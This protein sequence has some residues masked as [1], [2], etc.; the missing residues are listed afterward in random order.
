LKS[1]NAGIWQGDAKY[2]LL[3]NSDVIVVENWLDRLLA[4]ANTDHNIASVNPLTNHAANISIP[5]APGANYISMDRY[6]SQVSERRYPDIVT[7]VGFC[8]LLRRSVLDSVGVFDEIYGHGY[9]EESDLCMRF[10][11]NGYRTVIADDVYVYHK[12]SASFGSRDARYIKNRKIFDKRWNRIYKYQY[13]VFQKA[14]PLGYLRDSFK[15]PQRW[16][17][18]T[19]MRETYRKVLKRYLDRNY[20]G[21]AGAVL[22]GIY[23]LPLY[24]E[25]NVSTD[26]VAK[27]S[28]P[29]RLKVTYVLHKLTVAGGVLSVVQLV[30]ELILLGVEARIVTLYQYPETRQWKWYTCPIIYT[31]KDELINKLPE[32]DVVVATHWNTAHWVSSILSLGKAKTGVYFLQDYESWFFPESDIESRTKVKNT[33]AIIEHKI[34]KSSWLRNLLRKDG[35][36]SE[37]IWLGMDL[38]VFYPR[39]VKRSSKPTIM[40][41]A[42]P[43][44]PRRAF[45][46]LIE[47]LSIVKSESNEIDIIFFGEDLSKQDI[48]FDF[49]D[50][51][52][53]SNQSQL[54][55]LYSSADIFIDASD[56]QG[57]GR[58][59]LE[60]MACNTA[61][62]LTDVG[63]VTEY[64]RNEYNCLLVPPKQPQKIAHEV[65]RLLGDDELR[66]R[67]V[68]GG[69][70]TVRQ[71]SHKQEAKNTLAYFHALL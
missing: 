64:A 59:A 3:I 69:A 23:G 38:G 57:F 49:I 44:T 68:K 37:K 52:V 20:F 10:T 56:F 22:R 13:K 65:N 8:M 48:P 9:C 18:L 19:S 42:R 14:N 17:P 34:V 16:A 50:K 12:G 66:D 60:A 24:T 46:V 67:I 27:L 25:N 31:N 43:G 58:P 53:L 62:I 1:C 32:T 47:A 6:I 30:N 26:Y 61:C 41:M 45:G 70:D 15:V 36:R 51:G 5:I 63:G 54:A 4:C 39:D 7:G 2:A 21:A 29:G 28:C 40:A 71:F 11:T 35:Y 55:E 33:Y